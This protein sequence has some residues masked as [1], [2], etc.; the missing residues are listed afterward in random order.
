MIYRSIKRFMDIIFSL[1]ILLILF[2]FFLVVIIILRFT[3]EGEVFY[4]QERV[5]FKNEPFEILK[6]VT[7]VKNSANI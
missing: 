5:G 7:M 4:L 6:F 3:A 2:P 1:S